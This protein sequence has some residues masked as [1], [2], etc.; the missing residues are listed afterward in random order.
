MGCDHMTLTETLT[1][2]MIPNLTVPRRAQCL[3]S[4]ENFSPDE[5]WVTA[6][7]EPCTAAVQG[8]GLHRPRHSQVHTLLP[9]A[10][11]RYTS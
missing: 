6:L 9:S 1:A 5:L 3:R 2:V 7:K 10:P 4:C 11:V 8:T